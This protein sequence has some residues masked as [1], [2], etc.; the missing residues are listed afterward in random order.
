MYV[1]PSKLTG[2]SG[3]LSNVENFLKCVE[4]DSE[5]YSASRL[6]AADDTNARNLRV[7]AA[8]DGVGAGG[9]AGET[10]MGSNPHL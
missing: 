4:A 10:P 3:D 5:R 6:G 7:P 1:G 2:T 9:P 8:S